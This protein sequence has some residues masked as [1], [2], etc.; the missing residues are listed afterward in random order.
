MESNSQEST[1]NVVEIPENIEELIAAYLRKQAAR[2]GKNPYLSVT[3]YGTGA[4]GYIAGTWDD[5]LRATGTADDLESAV[6]NYL[7]V[8]DK[9]VLQRRDE[10]RKELAELELRAAELEP[11]EVAAS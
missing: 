1:T 6:K 8:R 7:N 4:I 2:A 11:Q 5:G 10:L 3:L 9:K